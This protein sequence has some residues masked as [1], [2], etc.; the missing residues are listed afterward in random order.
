MW[1]SPCEVV[2]GGLNGQL[3][4]KVTGESSPPAA[5]PRWQHYPATNTG[6]MT[7]FQAR[8][9]SVAAR[10]LLGGQSAG[11]TAHAAPQ[12]ELRDPARDDIEHRREDEPERGHADHAGEHR[13]AERLAQFGAGADRPD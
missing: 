4:Q 3:G 10:W 2:L 9:G 13:G 1:W 5:A 11:L 12:P 8:M 6:I 7:L